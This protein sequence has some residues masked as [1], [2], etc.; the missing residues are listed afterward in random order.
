MILVKEHV[1]ELPPINHFSTP[2]A[3][4]EMFFL[5]FAQF[6]KVSGIHLKSVHESP[7]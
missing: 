5:R 7:M 3:L 6:G 2:A 4:V 1:I